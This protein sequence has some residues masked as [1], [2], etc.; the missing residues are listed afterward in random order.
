MVANNR[1]VQRPRNDSATIGSACSVLSLAGGAAALAP[2]SGT[3]LGSGAAVC[4]D[5][6]LAACAADGPPD[7]GFAARPTW[8]CGA[9]FVA[10]VAADPAVAESALPSCVVELVAATCT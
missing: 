4:C 7:V 6:F 5:S 9:G 2:G 10:G 8:L 1:R 3:G